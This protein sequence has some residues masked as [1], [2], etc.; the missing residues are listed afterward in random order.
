MKLKWGI[1]IVSRDT[2]EH[3]KTDMYCASFVEQSSQTL[4][5]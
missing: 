1:Y 4:D 3:L 2:L 5:M